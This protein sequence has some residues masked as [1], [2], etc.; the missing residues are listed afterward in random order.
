MDSQ[1][2]K[3]RQIIKQILMRYA[4]QISNHGTIATRPAFDDARND[5]LLL[6]IGWDITGRVYSVFLYLY[7]QSNKI[8]IEVDG[9]EEGVAQDLLDANV[10]NDDIVLGLYRPR[11]REQVRSMCMRDD[12]LKMEA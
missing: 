8:W 3:Y 11:L 10:S 4:E 9:T 5:Y 2:E 1:L 12:I 6:D 7:I